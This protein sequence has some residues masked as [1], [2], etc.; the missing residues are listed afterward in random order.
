MRGIAGWLRNILCSV[1]R[2]VKKNLDCT[3]CNNKCKWGIK[4]VVFI[5]MFKQFFFNVSS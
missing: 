3:Y 2:L 1:E 5:K 4:P